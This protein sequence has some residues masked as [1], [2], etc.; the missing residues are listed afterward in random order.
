MA[1]TAIFKVDFATLALKN[2][3]NTPQIAHKAETTHLQ[4]LLHTLLHTFA[5]PLVTLIVPHRHPAQSCW[6]IRCREK[7]ICRSRL[8]DRVQT[9]HPYRR[10]QR[11]LLLHFTA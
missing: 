4:I 9:I 10:D 8:A 3:A 5:V 1:K 7:R 11:A 6:R 2:Q